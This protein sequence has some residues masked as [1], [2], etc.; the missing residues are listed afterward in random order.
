M[1]HSLAQLL[2]HFMD[3][4]LLRQHED[5][6]QLSDLDVDGIIVLAEEDTDIVLQHV[7]IALQNQKGVTQSQIL[8]LGPF[9][10]E[11]DE[12]WGEL[13]DEGVDDFC[14]GDV[15][16]E[17]EEDADGGH[18]DGGGRVRQARG[19][20]LGEDGGF[21]RLLRDVGGERLEDVDLAPSARRL[22]LASA[23][24]TRACR[25]EEE[26]K[27]PLRALWHDLNE[28]TRISVI[29]GQ[30]D[31]L[32]P[33]PDVRQGSQGAGDHD[34]VPVTQ[35]AVEAVDEIARLD[36]AAV[37]VVELGDGEGGRLAHVGVRVAQEALQRGGG[38]LD[39][40]ADVD[41]GDGA[42]GL[43]AHEGVAVF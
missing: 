7:R 18:D 19:D 3:I 41:G 39:E 2:E 32:A 14:V 24:C 28:I 1:I 10:E 38:G 34:G 42:E 4:P 11:R 21:G 6:L 43:G 12:R 25:R 29:E 33:A 9:R 27:N 40:L 36:E 22:L 20:A 8:D 16:E 37:V 17:V 30:L 35:H 23:P 26:T 13:D 5:D 31:A 15:V